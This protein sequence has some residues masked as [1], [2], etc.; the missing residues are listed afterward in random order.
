MFGDH[1]SSS[2]SSSSYS[3]SVSSISTVGR[4][5]G[6][7]LGAGCCAS[8]LLSENTAKVRL[9]FGLGTGAGAWPNVSSVTKTSWRTEE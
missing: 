4:E 3:E 8:R 1:S 5:R 6:A 9:G 2:F 7:G